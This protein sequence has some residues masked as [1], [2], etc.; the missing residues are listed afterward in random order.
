MNECMKRLNVSTADN[1]GTGLSGAGSVETAYQDNA[2][3]L[4]LQIEA[5]RI[6]DQGVVI[7]DAEDRHVYCNQTFRDFYPLSAPAFLPG[8]PFQDILRYSIAHGQI[9][10]AKGREDA[11]IAERIANRRTAG[12]T[13]ERTLLDGRVLRIVEHALPNG[14]LMEV[15]TDISKQFLAEQKLSNLIN[16]AEIC[17]WEWNV[18]TSEHRV[19]EYWAAAL[20]YQLDEL[21]PVSF[22][23]WRER[24][25]PDD[26]EA[27]EAMF[28]NLFLDPNY[29]Y[30]SEYRLRHKAASE[31]SHTDSG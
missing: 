17:S 10:E 23:T 7:Y 16:G 3:R 4:Q 28:D 27:A 9:V 24:V 11:W 14:A 5:L 31:Y 30:K 6:L 2:V 19:N 25:H 8:R 20:G 18:I 12:R 21:H 29:L 22:E 26:L 1:A 13:S 15:H